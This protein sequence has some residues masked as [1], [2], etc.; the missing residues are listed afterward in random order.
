MVGKSRV[1]PSRIARYVENA[2]KEYAQW[3]ESGRTNEEAGQ[4]WG[5]ML[6]GRR[7]DKKGKQIKK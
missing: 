7:Y 5:A 6:Q 1:H 2:A 4:F 3:N